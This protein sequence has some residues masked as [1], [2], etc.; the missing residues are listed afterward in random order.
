VALPITARQYAGFASRNDWSCAS[1]GSA[2][3]SH[4]VFF[5]SMSRSIFAVLVLACNAAL[6]GGRQAYTQSL[7]SIDIC[8]AALAAG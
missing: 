7:E 6:S 2:S 8:I 4:P 3:G 1:S 5:S